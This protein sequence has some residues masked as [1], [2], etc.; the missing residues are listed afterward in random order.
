MV[1]TI[2]LLLLIS[3]YTA[4]RYSK[5]EVDPDW[6]YFNL[7]GFTGAKYGKDFPD[8]KTPFIHLYYLGLSKIVGADVSRIKFA[9]H[10]LMGLGGIAVYLLS[11]NR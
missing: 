1:F 2:P 4:W 9:N 10:F 11:D 3:L 6:A 5:L 7:W 8:C